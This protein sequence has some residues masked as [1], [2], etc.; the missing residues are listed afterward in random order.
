MQIATA[1]T[2]TGRIQDRARVPLPLRLARRACSAVAVLAGIALLAPSMGEAQQRPSAPTWGGTTIVDV[3][4]DSTKI[5]SN[6]W[7]SATFESGGVLL[8]TYSAPT[9]NALV[10]A[11]GTRETGWYKSTAR[12]TRLGTL[13]TL[14]LASGKLS[15]TANYTPTEAGDYQLLAYCKSDS[16]YSAAVNLMGAGGRVT[17]TP[18]VSLSASRVNRTTARLTIANHGHPNRGNH[19]WSYKGNQTGAPCVSVAPGTASVVLTGLSANTSYTY[20]AYAKTG[21][22]DGLDD[23]TGQLALGAETRKLLG[24]ADGLRA[25]DTCSTANEITASATDAEF[26]TVSRVTLTASGITGTTAKLHIGNH[27]QAWYYKGEQTGATCSSQVAAGTRTASLTGLTADIAYTYKAYSNGTCTTE[28][29]GAATDAHFTTTVPASRP[30]PPTWNGSLAVSVAFGLA[31]DSTPALLGT[32]GWLSAALKSGY[33]LV[34]GHTSFVAADDL[35][36]ATGTREFGWY[37]STARTTRVGTTRRTPQ[38]HGALSQ[39]FYIPTEAGEYWFLAYCK[40]SNG[41]YSEPRNLLGANGRVAMTAPSSSLTAI[42]VTRTTATLLI[43]NHTQAWWLKGSQSGASCSSQIDAGTTEVGLTELSPGTSYTWTAYSKSGCAAADELGFVTFTTPTTP[44]VPGGIGLWSTTLTVDEATVG[45]DTYRG[46]SPT[47]DVGCS[48]ALSDD[49]F[50]YGGTSYTV[51]ELFNSPLGVTKRITLVLDKVIPSAI[52]TNGKL[53]LGGTSLS[54]SAATFAAANKQ[55]QWAPSGITWTDNQKVTVGLAMPGSIP[56][57]VGTITATA[58]N[59]Q[60]ELSWDKLAS[61]NSHVRRWQYRHVEGTDWSQSGYPYRRDWPSTRGAWPRIAVVKELTNGQQYSFQVRGVNGSGEVGP[62][63][64]VRATPALATACTAPT[65]SSA[66]VNGDKLTLT[67]SE[68]LGGLPLP[69]STRS[70]NELIALESAFTVKKTP[71]G[72]TEKTVALDSEYLPAVS[73]KKLFLT[74]AEAVVSTDAS[75]KVSY[76]KPT[77]EGNNKLKDLAGNE[78]ASFTDQAVTNAT[79]AGVPEGGA[80]VSLSVDRATVDEGLPVEVTATL[81]AVLGADVAIPVTLTAG[82]TDP[83]ESDDY[84][85]LASITVSAGQTSGSAAIVTNRDADADDDTFTVA[86]DAE[87]LPELVVAGEPSSATVTIN[88]TGEYT[89]TQPDPLFPAAPLSVEAT[90]GDGEVVLS[91]GGVVGAGGWEV[92]QG[93]GAWTGTGGT[94][95]SYTVTG[96]VNGTEYTFKVRATGL[97]PILKGT[98]SAR[99]SATPALQMSEAQATVPALPAPDWVRMRWE[100]SG[101]LLVWWAGVKP[102]VTYEVTRAD[103]NGS[104]TH[105]PVERTRTN[106]GIAG[107]ARGETHVVR[108]TAKSAEEGTGAASAP[109][110]WWPP[111]PANVAASAVDGTDSRVADVKLTWNAVSGATKYRY[112][113]KKG[114]G[115]AGAWTEAAGGATTTATVSGL[116]RGSGYRFEVEAHAPLWPG[117]RSEWSAQPGAASLAVPPLAQQAQAPPAPPPP[118][119]VRMRWEANGDLLVWWPEVRPGVTYEVTRA[120]GE[121][122]VTHGPVERSRT[123]AGIAGLD[124]D[125]THVVRVAAKSAAAGTGAA[126]EPAAWWP[127]APANVAASVVEGSNVLADVALSWGAVSGADKYRWRAKKGSDAAGAWT[128]AAGGATSVTVSGLE[129][130]HDYRF[131]VEAHAPLWPGGRS[132]WSAQ[133]GAATLTV[134]APSLAVADATAAEP[135]AGQAATLDF[136]VTL[137][138]AAAWTVTVDYATGKAGD[139]ATAGSDYTA[140]SGTLTLAAGETS[141]TVSVAVLADPHDDGGE[142]LTLALSN[143]S[144]ATISD[145]EATGTITNEGPIPQAWLA[146]FGRAAAADAVAAVTARLETPREAGSHLTVGGQ[147]LDLADPDGGAALAQAL[148]GLAR[149]LGAPG[150]SGPEPDPGG[151]PG[152]SAGFDG[153][154]AAAFDG[155]GAAASPVRTL[156]TR[157]LL[158]GTSF[159]AVLGTG[160]GAQWTGW[161]Q[162]ASVSAFSS[163]DPDLSLSGETATGSMGVDWERGRLIA[164]FAMTHSLGEGTAEGSGRSYAM[165]SSVTTLLPYARFALTERLSAW[166]LAGTGT[167]RLTLDLEGS[168]SERYGTDLAMA[169]AAVG[170]RGDLLTPAEAGGFALALK[171][172]AFRVRTESAAVAAPGTGHLAGAQAEASRVRAVLDGSRTFALAAGRSLTPSVALGLRHDG[173]DAETGTGVEVGAGVGYADPARGLDVALRVYGLAAHADDGYGDWGVS[174]SLR[175]APG[176]A[177]RGLTASLAPSYGTDPGGTE[178]LWT[179]PDAGAL[180]V[181]DGAPRSGRL[182]GEVGYGLP[183]PGG[184]TGTPHVG[185]GVSD[186]AREVR[187]GWRLAPAASGG[188]AFTLDATRRESGSGADPETEHRIGLGV[189]ASW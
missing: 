140:A 189:T 134:P 21:S 22:V 30:S 115:A 104:V 186:A 59:G 25:D 162:G 157:E 15:F 106:A 69:L 37:K 180:A 79:G 112:R 111:A 55:A 29:T 143:A 80:S 71:S 26:T 3:F 44:P 117:G 137:A 128:E 70:L 108:V 35:A 47:H 163:A 31:T 72:G 98:A 34:G 40:S 172:D 101:G 135:G 159:R 114:S 160:A 52:R 169:F 184:F 173:G 60:V 146:R 116:E 64:E 90:P 175:L 58:C 176:A 36:C 91:W 109:A 50:S 123:N 142:T 96:L 165:G 107:L 148:A 164:G 14:T 32:S 182:D 9:A 167:G 174:G 8:G 161:G 13:S 103:G 81:S 118:S 177:G 43:G 122:T 127:P 53:I 19:G 41:V 61:G 156:R 131:E 1:R 136:T 82:A 100:D 33:R 45:T 24:L 185:F 171:A 16:I 39:G 86:V 151:W 130:G 126:S 23:L 95:R 93:S 7:L 94:D 113:V 85:P 6:G 183:V 179:L 5:G 119:W 12:T 46:C 48:T 74:L 42:A 181:D 56:G 38:A 121:G 92:Q 187:M 149:L 51:E 133:P 152:H 158:T 89:V 4:Y 10:C 141:K 66:S 125:G 144:G 87:S 20:K 129:R 63:G 166:G 154:P 153:T 76:T 68:D 11:T 145:A 150:G 17:I 49:G 78:T 120:D 110:A 139:T 18:P 155:P 28:L 27:G 77:A 178:R 124:R 97:L 54:F 84:N 75:V 102:G 168:A 99:V 105:G 65:V 67:F 83:A 138:P 132:E 73:G 62:H 188:F 147:R 2:E 88:D 57:S 170:V